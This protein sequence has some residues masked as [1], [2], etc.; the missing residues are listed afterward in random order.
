MVI[1]TLPGRTIS[2]KS[3]FL[4]TAQRSQLGG[5]ASLSSASTIVVIA[6]FKDRTTA[7]VTFNFDPPNTVFGLSINAEALQYFHFPCEWKKVVSLSFRSQAE[8]GANI[9]TGLGLDNFKYVDDTAA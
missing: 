1:S 7:Q 5:L 3:V 8:N 9:L 2:P 4:G 6:T